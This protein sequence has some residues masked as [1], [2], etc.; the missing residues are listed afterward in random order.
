[1]K[2]G[3]RKPSIKRSIKARTTGKLKRQV[4]KAIN[5]MYGKK[6]MGMITD[7]KKAIYNKVYNKTTI[8]VSDLV[9]TSK[10]ESSKA[11]LNDVPQ[12]QLDDIVVCEE[13][14][15][16][17]SPTT[18]KV[19]S[20]LMKILA[21]IT[22]IIFGLPGLI[23]GIYLLLVIAIKHETARWILGVFLTIV[24]LITAIFSTIH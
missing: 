4:K 18:W 14:K 20:V 7:P 12:E 11:N 21:V 6:G 24:L 23:A 19:C 17:V 5:P 10:G 15:N 13:T 8:G 3:F 1:M 2:I 9:K 22:A 16:T